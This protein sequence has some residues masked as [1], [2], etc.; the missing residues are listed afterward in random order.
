M[1]FSFLLLNNCILHCTT[2]CSICLFPRLHTKRKRKNW[3]LQSKDGLLCSLYSYGYFD[4]C[5][6]PSFALFR[7]ERC[8]GV[9]MSRSCRLAPMA[10]LLHM[11]TLS[12]YHP[13]IFR[14]GE[15]ASCAFLSESSQIWTCSA[16][17]KASF[18]CCQ[19]FEQ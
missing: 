7:E 19:I 2:S 8:D 9:T 18:A 5:I 11:I 13:C 17:V 3:V 1:P 12:L 16:F 4:K 10:S 14:L 15:T 6:P